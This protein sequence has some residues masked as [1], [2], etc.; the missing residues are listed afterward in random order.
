MEIVIHGIAAPLLRQETAAKGVAGIDEAQG[1][2]APQRRVGR[3]A[4]IGPLGE[5]RRHTALAVV[6]AHGPDPATGPLE[7]NL[8]GQVD[9][10]GAFLP[11]HERQRLEYG[12][13]RGLGEATRVDP[14]VVDPAL[15]PPAPDRVDD[16]LERPALFGEGVDRARPR[17]DRADESRGDQRAQ[18]AGEDPRRDSGSD[19]Q[20][21]ETPG[22]GQELPPE[23]QGPAIADHL[24]GP[25]HRVEN[26]LG[27][28]KPRQRGIVDYLSHYNGSI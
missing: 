2:T 8:E 26:A 13:G 24:E 20:L 5:A 6:K 19:P 3:V 11:H 27:L 15:D 18:P 12:L 21:L 28:G 4:N 17:R 23:D 7:A 1:D 14:E 10:A 16:G 22:R 9:V 25:G